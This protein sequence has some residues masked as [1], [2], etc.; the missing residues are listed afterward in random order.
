[1]PMK[2]STDTWKDWDILHFDDSLLMS[3]LNSA[4]SAFAPFLS[5]QNLKMVLDLTMA[6]VVDS[7]AISFL[8]HAQDQI[9][10]N[11]GEFAIICPN[12][13]TRLVFSVVGLEKE[14]PIFNSLEDFQ[15]NKS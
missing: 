2:S 15:K 6:K 9:K 12:T 3:N 8:I 13:D 14:I 10:E 4:R 5:R 11:G 7:S 1:M